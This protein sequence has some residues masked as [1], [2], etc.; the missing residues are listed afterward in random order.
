MGLVADDI[1]KPTAEIAQQIFANFVRLVLNVSESSLTTLPLSANCD[2]DP[3]LHKKSIP[4]IILFQCMKAFIKDNSGNKLDLT[5]CDLVTPAKHEHRF[6]KLTSFLVDFLKLHELA[7]PAFNEISEEFSDR[8]FEMEKIRE[9]LLEAEKKKNDL[10]A[11]QSIR[12]RHEHELINEQSNAKAELKNVVNEY[13]ETRQINEELDKQKEEAILHIQALEK[14]MLTGKKTIEHLN[15]EVLT[16]PEQLKQEMEER[17]R[18][19]EELRDCLESSKKGLQAKLE[20]RE[21]CI[22]SEKNVPVIIEKIHQWTEVREVIIDLIDVESENLRKLKEMEEQLDFMMKEMETAQ[23]RLVEQSET[24]E[25]LRIEHTQK[26]EERQRRIEEI[27]EQIANLKTS[28][29]DVSQEIAKKK[30]ELLALKN[31]HSE[32]ISQ[33]TNSCQ[34]AV[35][36]FAKLNAMFKETQKVAFEKNTAAAR[37][38]ERLKSSL[39]GRLLSDYTF[40]SSTIDAGENTEN[41]DPQPNDS[42]FSVFK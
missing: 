16:S 6:R 42:S 13:T 19:I 14:E 11:K 27:T 23:K 8:K 3:E 30:Q 5:M 28:Q 34:D 32:T 15:E 31:A 37:E 17:K 22:N 26:S 25:Q 7:T 33:I 24:H 40:G 12:K 41:C 10:L 2:Y 1:I 21:I 36:K 38:M 18:H 39:T 29:P 9:E 35:A 20:A 4:I